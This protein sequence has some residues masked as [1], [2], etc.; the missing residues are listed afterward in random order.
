MAERPPQ[1][2]DSALSPWHQ[3]R[4]FF[5]F[6]GNLGGLRYQARLGIY[7]LSDPNM[8]TR[9][10]EI[11]AEPENRLLSASSADEASSAQDLQ[12]WESEGGAPVNSNR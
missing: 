6:E 9:A 3:L 11:V 10:N 5:H 8:F 12:T 1:R 2:P 4:R 7:D